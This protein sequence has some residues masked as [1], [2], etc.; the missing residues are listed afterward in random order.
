MTTRHHGLDAV[1]G[2]CALVV[3]TYH[4]L[5]W[6]DV[7]DYPSLAQF[8]V[9]AFFTLSSVTLCMVYGNR[10]SR[11]ISA[12][13]VVRYAINR[14]SRILPLLALA[15]LMAIPINL[16]VGAPIP[17]ELA[18]AFFTGSGL[19]AFGPAGPLG[20]A[21]GTWSLGIELLFYFLFPVLCIL[22][23]N[24][25]VR[26]L[27]AVAGITLLAQ[28][29]FAWF[30]LHDSTVEEKWPLYASPLSFAFYFIAGFAGYRV[31]LLHRFNMLVGLTLVLG[32]VCISL[33]V[34]ATATQLL[35]PPYSLILPAMVA[36]GVSCI[37]HS[38]A[39]P[40]AIR[41]FEFLGQ[42]SYSSYLLHPFAFF[43]VGVFTRHLMPDSGPW[44]YG[45]LYFSLTV[46]ASVASY[47]VIEVP[48]RDFIRRRT[49]AA[50]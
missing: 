43:T 37:F 47:R 14:A 44:V 21:G 2:L 1:R 16:F 35:L 26:T 10:F 5:A 3:A 27:V 18:K 15:A 13:D 25:S 42:I 31:K 8:A 4:F 29:L 49:A 45:L 30:M 20:N 17:D 28:C 41:A 33:L 12:D 6:K 24:R 22:L 23:I 11:T 38:Q 40:A 7:A 36:L 46:A 9:Y 50:R 34:P 39:H 48:V 19:F 32:A